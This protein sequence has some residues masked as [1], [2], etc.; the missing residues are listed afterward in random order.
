MPCYPSGVV[1]FGA[2]RGVERGQHLAPC[3]TGLVHV[4]GTDIDTNEHGDAL[5]VLARCAP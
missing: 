1:E 3:G 4:P 5:A 2:S